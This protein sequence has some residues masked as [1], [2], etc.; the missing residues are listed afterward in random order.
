MQSQRQESTSLTTPTQKTRQRAVKEREFKDDLK[1]AKFPCIR[2]DDHRIE[3]EDIP[4][5]YHC[6]FDPKFNW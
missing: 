2:V 6:I 4:E 1:Y 5:S 3:G